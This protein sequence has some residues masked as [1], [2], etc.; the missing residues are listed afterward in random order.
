MI[1]KLQRYHFGCYCIHGA[2][3]FDLTQKF[4]VET[5]T[6]A[7]RRCANKI[8]LTPSFG[9]ARV[10]ELSG[11]VA[12]LLRQACIV[13]DLEPRRAESEPDHVDA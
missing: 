4:K 1:S 10:E 7:W 12:S 3:N 9:A 8:I 13:F 2:R 5:T 6:T 11:K